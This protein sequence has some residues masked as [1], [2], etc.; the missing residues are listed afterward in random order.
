MSPSPAASDSGDDRPG[1]LGGL[2]SSARCSLAAPAVGLCWH[3]AG[4]AVGENWTDTLVALEVPEDPFGR[5]L[6][7]GDVLPG[8]GNASVAAVGP[9]AAVIRKDYPVAKG[10]PLSWEIQLEEL[11]E[12]A[13]RLA[14]RQGLVRSRP[15][16]PAAAAVAVDEEDQEPQSCCPD[17]DFFSSR[18]R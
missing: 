12:G 18:R 7:R 10:G 4:S 17:Y 6:R 1:A 13:R 16:P 5:G 14:L 9:R 15:A 8:P 11:E 2:G 3:T